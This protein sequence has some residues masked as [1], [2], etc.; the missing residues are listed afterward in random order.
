[1]DREEK[2]ITAWCSKYA[3]TEGL[4]E[5]NGHISPHISET[6]LFG[7]HKKGATVPRY[8]GGFCLTKKEWHQ[9]REEAVVRVQ[10]MIVKKLASLEKSKKKLE[11]LAKELK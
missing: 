8:G 10:K 7:C 9:T 1:M 3:L 5:V 4:F 6:T 2:P 11:K